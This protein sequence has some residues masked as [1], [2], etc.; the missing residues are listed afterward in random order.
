[1]PEW[2]QKIADKQV[3]MKTKLKYLRPNPKKR[4]II[5]LVVVVLLVVADQLTKWLVVQNIEYRGFI[6]GLWIGEVRLIDITHIHNDGAAFGMLSGQQPLLIAV[7]SVVLFAAVVAVLSGRIRD[8]WL[9][10]AITMIVAGGIGNLIDRVSQGYV[11]DFIELQFV[12]FAVFN[13]ADIFAVAGA[14]LMC[15]AVIAEE[16]RDYRAK[17]A[18]GVG[19]EQQTTPTAQPDE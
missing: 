4:E 2:L 3:R 11:V 1:V 10:A 12:R 17:R 16:V 8:R 6:R 19:E 9:L 18:C 14:I 15:L 7:T 5:A 13:V